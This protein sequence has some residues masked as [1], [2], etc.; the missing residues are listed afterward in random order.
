MARTDKKTLEKTRMR[1][2][3]YLAIHTEENSSQGTSFGSMA[4]ALAPTENRVRS[5]CRTLRDD[6]LLMVE[7]R[8]DEDG[9]QK[10]NRYILTSFG[11]ETL[12]K[13]SA[14][15]AQRAPAHP[16]AVESHEARLRESM[17]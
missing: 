13:A 2:L 16:E 14:L 15:V 17:R 3:A 1:V 12:R 6:G 4:R 8:F 5:A 11:R 7:A 10:A 9:G